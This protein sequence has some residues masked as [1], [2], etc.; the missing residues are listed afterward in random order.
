M[1]LAPLKPPAMIPSNPTIETMIHALRRA[2]MA[3]ATRT[4]DAMKSNN[5][6]IVWSC[7]HSGACISAHAT[8]CATPEKYSGALVPG[9]AAGTC[10]KRF[11]SIPIRNWVASNTR[12]MAVSTR[13]LDC[14]VVVF[15][16]LLRVSVLIKRIPPICEHIQ[17][18]NYHKPKGIYL[19][20]SSLIALIK[21]L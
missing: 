15:V 4:M 9:C 21:L 18:N 13:S 1:K 11:T 5:P 17:G 20:N 14:I 2:A 19:L 16:S 6:T 3:K 7:N 12:M 10:T 8:P